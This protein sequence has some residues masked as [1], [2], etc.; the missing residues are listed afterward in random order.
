MCVR[1]NLYVYILRYAEIIKIFL[2]DE[3]KFLLLLL[4][5]KRSRNRS[6]F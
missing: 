1:V 3:E 4:P 5:W 6:L 2:P